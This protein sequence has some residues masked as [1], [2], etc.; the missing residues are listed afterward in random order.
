[1]LW[2]DYKNLDYL[3][4]LGLRSMQ[5]LNIVNQTFNY[6][7]KGMYEVLFEFLQRKKTAENVNKLT[8]SSYLTM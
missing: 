2:Y 8:S 6:L 3:G 5:G 7:G 4:T 1:M